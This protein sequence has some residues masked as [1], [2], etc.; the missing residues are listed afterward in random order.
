MVKFNIVFRKRVIKLKDSKITNF[1]AIR[2]VL[3]HCMGHKLYS[4]E[5]TYVQHTT[6]YNTQLN[7]KMTEILNVID[8]LCKN[9]PC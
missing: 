5:C 3:S 6:V 7:Y 4:K 8:C 2:L 1:M 9:P